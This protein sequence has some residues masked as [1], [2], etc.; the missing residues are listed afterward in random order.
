MENSIPEKEVQPEIKPTETKK[1]EAQE[2]KPSKSSKNGKVI[3]IVVAV[4]AFLALCSCCGTY[5][6]FIF[7]RNMTEGAERLAE[8]ADQVFF[9]TTIE[10][11][12]ASLDFYYED[13]GYYPESLEE[14]DPDYMIYDTQFISDYNVSYTL[15]NDGQSYLIEANTGSI[16]YSYE[17]LDLSSGSNEQPLDTDPVTIATHTQYLLE[18]YFFAFGYYPSSLE[19]LAVYGVYTYDEEFMQTY[20]MSYELVAENMD[21]VLKVD[22]ELYTKSNS[23]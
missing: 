12:N 13:Y 21:Y 2:V 8:D 1:V 20:D 11:Y 23:Q 15:Q 3:A 22:G 5:A 10:N 14:L 4:L 17:P 18:T 7:I 19:E 16:D 6:G 9:Y